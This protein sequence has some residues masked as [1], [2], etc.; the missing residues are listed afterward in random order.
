MRTGGYL[1]P[2]EQH[3]AIAAALPD[4]PSVTVIENSGHM[5][6]MEQPEAVTQAMRDWL[7]RQ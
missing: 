6:T 3:E 4:H 1:S 5:S 7:E 2:L